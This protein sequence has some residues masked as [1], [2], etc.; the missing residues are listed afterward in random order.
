MEG[1]PWGQ[2]KDGDLDPLRVGVFSSSTSFRIR[3]LQ[4]LRDRIGK[5]ERT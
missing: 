3:A 4:E 5:S 1:I 2:V